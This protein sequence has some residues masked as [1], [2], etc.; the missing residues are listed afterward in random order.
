MK[1]Q[2]ILKLIPEEYF[3][4]LAAETKVDYKVK[5]LHGSTVFKL[6]LYSLL[7]TK[8]G[9]LRVMESIFSS[10]S[11]KQFSSLDKQDKTRFTSIRDRLNTINVEYFHRLF[12][13]CYQL[14][15]CCL[16]NEHKHILRY[17]STVVALSGKLLNIGIEG[18]G[19]STRKQVK[20]SV[21]FDGLLPT[22]AKVFTQKEYASE[23]V[24]L[25]ELIMEASVSKEDISVF[26]RGLMSR[27]TYVEF[28]DKQKSFVTRIKSN[29]RFKPIKEI[30]FTC[31][32]DSTVSIKDDQW[33]YLYSK[34]T[35]VEH[36][37]RLVRATIKE[38]KEDIYFLTNI[39]EL[40]AE[41]IAQIYKRR[42][43]IEVFFRFIKQELNFNHIVSESENA[44]KVM[45]YMSMI[46][47]TLIIAYKKFNNLKGYKIPKLKFALELEEEL[48]KQVVIICG[49]DPS[50][51][52]VT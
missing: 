7:T 41:E 3:E 10:Y 1:A 21:G 30:P 39:S 9:S 48:I 8:K 22:C 13:E 29:T 15:S 38:T 44:L 12:S 24:A 51:M 18:R 20:F 11:F 40:S 2:E 31:L 37:F 25:R 43:E 49:G 17:D 6:I 32:E 34:A 50:K 27:R 16:E 52:Y 35:L 4:F 36:P 47:A 46:T 33:V 23:D 5:K 28:D 42:W 19:K 26:D 14:F 45:L